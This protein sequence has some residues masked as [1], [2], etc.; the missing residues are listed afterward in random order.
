MK[1]IY[2]FCQIVK[3]YGGYGEK[4]LLAV[5][6]WLLAVGCWFWCFAFFSYQHFPYICVNYK[7]ETT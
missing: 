2:F 1:N 6:Y 5:G 3:K 7:K 4:R